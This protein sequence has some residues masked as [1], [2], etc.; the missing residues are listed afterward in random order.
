M[1]V[2]QAQI[3]QQ[4]PV[5]QLWQDD[6][7]P[8]PCSALLAL[9]CITRHNLLQQAMQHNSVTHHSWLHCTT[10]QCYST[11]QYS[12]VELGYTALH[13]TTLHYITG[14]FTSLQ[15]YYTTTP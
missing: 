4:S 7:A 12:S 10:L 15:S 1:K 11:V 5:I 3:T 13:Y 6:E 8:T 14:G 9:F 2:N